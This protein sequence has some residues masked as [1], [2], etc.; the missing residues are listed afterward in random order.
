MC[1]RFVL[2]ASREAVGK[3]FG[4]QIAG[5]YEPRY[6][7]AP[8][9]P[10]LTIHQFTGTV[11][12]D[13]ASWGLI[14]SWHKDPENAQLL[15][16]ARSETVLDKPSFKNAVRHHRVL[17]PATHFYEWRRVGKDRQPYCVDRKAPDGEDGLFAMAGI[18]DEWAG[19]DGEIFSTLAILTQDADGAIADIHHR[20]PV[21]VPPAHYAPWLD[22]L[23]LEAADAL[24]PLR[25]ATPDAWKLWPV[26]KVV[27][28]AG[29]DGAQLLEE[30]QPPAPEPDPQM[31]LF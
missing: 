31:D 6:N 29:V 4:V 3:L 14:P 10:V 9:Q 25:T 24:G 26:D 5:L 7:I 27:N 21:V 23:N 19:K 12:A 20:M 8:S 22:C 1:G 30:V 18:L 28:R 17:V 2:A 16:N 15:M 13:Y 11:G